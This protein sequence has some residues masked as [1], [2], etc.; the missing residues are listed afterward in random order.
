MTA[1]CSPLG[2]KRTSFLIPD[3]ANRSRKNLEEFVRQG[4]GDGRKDSER[5][6]LRD[7][8]TPKEAK[9]RAGAA[10]GATRE[11]EGRGGSRG[12]AR[13]EGP[14]KRRKQVLPAGCGCV[15]AAFPMLCLRSQIRVPPLPAQGLPVPGRRAAILFPKEPVG[16]SVEE[17]SA[18]DL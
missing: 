16:T 11:S 10:G 2:R 1:A 8:V 14:C 15:S 3:G 18:L 13:R 17:G 4:G 9:R 5:G 7:L 6:P 12:R